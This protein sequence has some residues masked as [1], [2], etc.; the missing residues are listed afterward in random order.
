MDDILRF[1]DTNQIIAGNNPE[2]MFLTAWIGILEISTG[3]LTASNAGHEYPVLRHPGGLYELH[4]DKHGFV[5]G[6]MKDISYQNYDLFLEPGAKLFMYTD[7]LPEATN[8]EGKAFG[9]DRMMIALNGDPG[10]DPEKDLERVRQAVDRFIGESEQFD[11]LTMLSL[12]YLG[13]A[14]TKAQD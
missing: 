14:G 3:K 13:S 11:D 4:R 5:L 12:E 8:S 1:L 2:E 7:G 10:S 6:A 9:P